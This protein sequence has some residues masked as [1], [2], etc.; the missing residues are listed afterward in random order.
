MSP[1]RTLRVCSG[2]SKCTSRSSGR[3]M[4][5]ARSCAGPVAGQCRVDEAL[6]RA[7][8]REHAAARIQRLKVSHQHVGRPQ[9]GGDEGRLRP[10]VDRPWRAFLDDPALRHDGDPVGQGERLGL[11]VRHVERGDADLVDQIVQLDA[12]LVA[13][14]GVQVRQRLVE[15]QQ[16][17]LPHDGARQGDPLLLAARE[18]GGGAPGHRF[19]ADQLQGSHHPVL[20]LGAGP[21][22]S[23][24]AQRIRHVLEHVQVRPDRVGLEH[25]ANRAVVHLDEDA[26]RRVGHDAPADRDGP[27]VGVFEAGDAA[28]RRGLAA[29]AGTEQGIALAV[30]DIEADAIDDV[31][32]ALRAAK[33]LR[34]PLDSEHASSPRSA[35]TG[36]AG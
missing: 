21:A 6:A 31:D 5:S 4:I 2:G 20:D 34:Q 14:P 10:L 3:M 7:I 9:E 15:Q 32:R 35:R 33:G 18:H 28:Q 19:H 27:G 25:H 23:L 30:G 29:A 11:V 22:R 12:H 36:A 24:D 1:A 17:R 13:H 26:A 8:D 16:R